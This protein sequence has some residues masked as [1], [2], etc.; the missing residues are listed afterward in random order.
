MRKW[1]T[2]NHITI[3]IL[4]IAL[5]CLPGNDNKANN[6]FQYEGAVGMVVQPRK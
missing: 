4:A 6:A 1:I 5:R 2:C 3:V